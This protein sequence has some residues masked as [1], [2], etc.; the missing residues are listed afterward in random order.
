MKSWTNIDQKHSP[1]SWLI[2]AVI[3]ILTWSDINKNYL[4][5]R[6]P[7][8]WC[9]PGQLTAL[10]ILRI[11]AQLLGTS[12]CILDLTSPMLHACW[13]FMLTSEFREMQ[14]PKQSNCKC[15]TNSHG[16]FGA[17]LTFAN[18]IQA[19]GMWEGN[20]HWENAS[21]KLANRQAHGALSWLMINV[22]GPIHH[23]W[24]H[25]WAGGSALCKNVGGAKLLKQARRGKFL[26]DLCFGSCLHIPTL[27]EFLS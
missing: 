23:R 9:H 27:F 13:R 24:C 11:L 1:W 17:A 25:I 12:V 14:I 8:K 7:G 10:H 5:W 4:P 18:R 26:L 22:A 6:V 21:I 19:G 16:G 20:L 3:Q 2:M 15:V